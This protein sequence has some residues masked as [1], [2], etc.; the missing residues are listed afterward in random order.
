MSFGL[1]NA[2]QTLQCFMDKILKDLDFCFAYLDDILVFSRS[3]EEHDEHLHTLFT[4][5]L[6]YSILLNPAKRVFS[7]PKI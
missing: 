2:T 7:V 4:K 6:N 3:S 5:L 1:Q